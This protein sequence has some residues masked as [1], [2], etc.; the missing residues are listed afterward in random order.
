MRPYSLLFLGMNRLG[1]NLSILN[2]PKLGLFFD[3]FREPRLVGVPV[4][5]IPFRWASSRYILFGLSA[6]TFSVSLEACSKAWICLQCSFEINVSI[7]A[8]VIRSTRSKLRR[9]LSCF[10]HLWLIFSHCPTHTTH[11]PPPPTNHYPP[12]TTTTW[13]LSRT[14]LQQPGR[15][16]PRQV[17][18][19][20]H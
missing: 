9:K 4:L 12:P 6:Y 19:N 11:P 14:R 5:W 13:R 3:Y 8:Y 1:H 20:L 16:F 2:L 17:A 18:L 7:L 15:R 10:L